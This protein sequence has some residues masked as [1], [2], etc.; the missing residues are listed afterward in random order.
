M[1][2]IAIRPLYE[3]ILT[4]ERATAREGDRFTAVE[5]APALARR[6]KIAE[7]F[8]DEIGEPMTVFAICF[9]LA[10]PVVA[11]LVVGLNR[12]E[13]VDGIARA[14]EP[15]PSQQMVRRPGMFC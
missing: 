6:R 1:G 5:H 3:G 9:A 13:Q 12:P 14:V 11:S 8:R 2:F 7:A 15:S 10:G 4:D